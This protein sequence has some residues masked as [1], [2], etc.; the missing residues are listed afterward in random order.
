MKRMNKLTAIIAVL[1][2]SS[3][4]GAG[5][6]KSTLFSAENAALGNATKGV[7]DGADAV[8]LNPAGLVNGPDREYTFNLSP[9]QG[10]FS[11]PVVP[12]T[13]AKEKGKKT[14]SPIFG[15]TSKYNIDDKMAWGYGFYSL[16]GTTVDY[17]RVD[18]SAGNPGLFGNIG[19]DPEI[20]SSLAILE[21]TLAGAYKIQ[22]NWSVGLGWRATFVRADY[23]SFAVDGADFQ[24][25]EFKDLEDNDFGGFRL[26]TQYDGGNWGVGFVYRTKV[27]FAAEGKATIAVENIGTGADSAPTSQDVE[28][29][30]VLPSAMHL[31]FHYDVDES[32]RIFVGYSKLDYSQNEAFEIS[33]GALNGVNIPQN[34][35]DSNIYRLAAEYKGFSRP[36]RMSYAHVT[37]STNEDYASAGYTP[38]GSG[39]GIAV[40]STMEL[41]GNDFDY[42]FEFGGAEASDARPYY[43]VANERAD[44]N[45]FFAALHMSYKLPW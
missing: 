2:A 25:I 33:G 5:F 12:G 36:L 11:G 20:M 27:E 19:N 44:F 3:A 41:A 35:K 15:I 13:T 34:W 24:A 8:L 39:Y 42:A 29:A 9:T 10:Q 30:N 28:I 1:F 32:L 21:F 7:V 26:G 43:H 14:V 18:F 16:A 6:E 40:G 4:M 38:A 37:P 23:S 45:S 31:D 22:D 17:G